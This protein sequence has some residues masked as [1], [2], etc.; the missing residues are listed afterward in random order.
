MSIPEFEYTSTGLV[1]E[2]AI[3][4][5][6]NVPTHD[7]WAESLACCL[8]GTMTGMERRIVTNFGNIY[9]NVFTIYVGASGLSFKTVPLIKLARPILKELTKIS[10]QTTC[11]EHGISLEQ[12]TDLVESI[13][14]ATSIEK[15]TTAWQLRKQQLKILQQ[16]FEDFVGPQKFSSEFLITW[17]NQHP[18]CMIVSDE[19]TKMFK[20]AKTKDYLS[21]NMED[22]SRLYD[23]DMEKV[24]TQSRGIENPDKAFVSFCSATTYYLL[25]MM[26]DDFF[27]QGTGNRILWI[28]DD[29]RQEID[30]EAALIESNFFWGINESHEFDEQIKLLA[31]KLYIIRSLPEGVIPFDPDA[32][33]ILDR[34]RL[35][36]YNEAVKHFNIDLLDKDA[37]LIARLAQNAMKLALTHCIGRYA[38]L[39]YNGDPVLS[40]SVSKHD[41]TWAIQKMEKHL[42]HYLTMKDVASR[43]RNTTARSYATDYDRVVYI[44]KKFK[45][46]GE[47]TT[48]TRIMQQTRWNSEETAKIL[49][50]MTEANLIREVER[51]M[52]V[53]SIITYDLPISNS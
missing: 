44:I 19:Y 41:V 8:I 53:R 37:N 26:N 34:Y 24:G 47:T 45:Q 10:N 50:S 27:I 11:E 28:F 32:G 33:V 36:K 29:L 13:D 12:Y 9:A 51:L 46:G 16:N 22:L 23:C 48:K 6:T 30:I 25:T 5:H 18:Q 39:Q 52:G 2:L 7:D 3:A 14:N 1:R 17:L 15:R 4:L 21:D 42:Q 38:E 43:V 49:A 40:M 31:Q 35:T 20:G